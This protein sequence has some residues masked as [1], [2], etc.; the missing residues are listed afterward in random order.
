MMQLRST[1]KMA[2]QSALAIFIAEWIALYFSPERGYWI[3]ISA[4][5]LT[6]QT[7]GESAKRSLERVAMTILG[8][9]AGTLLYFAIPEHHS[10]LLLG[11]VLVFIFLTIYT[12]EIYS[13]ASVFFLTCFVVFLFA[14][15]GSWTLFL[16]MTRIIDTALGAVIALAVGYCLFSLKTNIDAMFVDYL[17]KMKALLSASFDT[18][19][20]PKTLLT[21]HR[22]TQDFKKIKKSAISV[23]Y[24][25]VFHRLS[26]RDFNQLLNDTM[27]CTRYVIR[28]LE[29]YHWLA[30]HLQEE[31]RAIIMAAKKMTEHNIEALANRL[32]KKTSEAML[33]ADHL[34]QLV[35]KAIHEEPARFATL[36]SDAL[37][38]FNLICF[39]SQLNHSLNDMGRILGRGIVRLTE[40]ALPA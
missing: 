40:D 39:F 35:A 11:L 19:G 14:L 10:T 31:E 2:I 32:Q 24:E 16:L 25:L 9:G 1:T 38:F 15:M 23:R 36:D 30:P 29:S 20:Q 21:T 33:T 5:V 17:Q 27:F 3:T 12:A 26:T 37:G 6:A 34:T 13:L 8:G 22:L 28:L 7:W 18:K 4:M